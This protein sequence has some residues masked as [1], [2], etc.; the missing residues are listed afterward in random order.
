MYA[1]D[2][3][4]FA[5]AKGR[6][7]MKAWAVKDNFGDLQA[8]GMST[9]ELFASL[10]YQRLI[11][12]ER[13]PDGFT[14]VPVEITEIVEGQV[15]SKEPDYIA[16]WSDFCIQATRWHSSPDIPISTS[17]ILSALGDIKAKHTPKPETLED[18]VRE[19]VDM[20]HDFNNP[21]CR[22]AKLLNK[23]RELTKGE[24]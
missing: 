5:S 19:F 9:T 10:N 15:E 12:V 18:V 11:G 1:A 24:K 16:M 6:C 17:Y 20:S 21:E 14:V 13:L 8:C 7:E 23:M 22:K 3:F 4:D 2:E